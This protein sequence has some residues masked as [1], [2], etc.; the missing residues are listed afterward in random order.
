MPPSAQRAAAEPAT[1]NQG[2]TWSASVGVWLICDASCRS[3]SEPP[4]IRTEDAQG[5]GGIAELDECRWQRR[6][7]RGV[8]ELEKEAIVPRLVRGA[9]LEL[10]HVDLVRGER[11][12][13]AEQR[14]R[15][16]GRGDEQRGA[17]GGVRRRCARRAGDHQKA[18]LVVAA[19][20]DVRR[21]DLQPVTPRS[22]TPRDRRR[23]HVTSRGYVARRARGIVRGAR[24]DGWMRTQPTRALRERN[25]M[26]LHR[27]EPIERRP[28]YPEHA[29]MDLHHRCLL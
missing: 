2:T 10:A 21:E 9:R 23:P 3:S 13:H 11:L 8:I 15:N 6:I 28:P 29:V 25:R 20:L 22:A 26:A 14:A 17:S 16:V 24:A 5:F 27:R 18:R 7:P 12:E 19:V 4:G 1:A